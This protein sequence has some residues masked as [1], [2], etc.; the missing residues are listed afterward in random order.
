MKEIAENI[1]IF[2]GPNVRFLGLDIPT[3]M[4]IIRNDNSLWVH[5]PIPITEEIRSFLGDNGKVEHIV[6]PNNLH[7]L[8]LD[9]WQEQYTDANFVAAPGVR[10]KRPDLRFD[11][12]LSRDK[13]YIWSDNIAHDHFIGNNVV[14][15][16]VFFH[17]ASSTLILTDLIINLIVDDFNWL[18][19]RFAR[20]DGIAYPNGKSPRLFR[21][22]TRNR[23]EARRCYQQMLD[24]S[25]NQIVISHG[26]CFYTDGTNELKQRLG[27]VEN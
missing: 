8:Y 11:V 7:H 3:R 20:F 15:E 25:P 24:W 5:S 2:D 13:T 18:Q 14:E 4:T 21:W 10:E 23:T 6:A 26:E 9:G 19:K 12:D 22:G 27:W 1:W 16:V 17:K